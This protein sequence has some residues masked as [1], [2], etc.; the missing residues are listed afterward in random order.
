MLR[1]LRFFVLLSFLYAALAQA[2]RPA[3]SP[4]EITK[5]VVSAID[6]RYLYA[7]SN[8]AWKNARS[9]ILDANNRDQKSTYEFIAAELA[10]LRDSELHLVTPSEAAAIDREGK[11]TAVG[12]GLI[13]FGID[14]VPETGEARVVTPW[15]GSPA[16]NKGVRPRD[17]I[18][19]V[20]GKPTASL[21]HEQVADALRQDAA[22]LVLRRGTKTLH[23]R[24]QRSEDP[25]SAVVGEVKPASGGKIAYIRIAQFTP[26]SGDLVRAKVKEFES[27]RLQGYILDLRNNPGGFLSATEA[28]ASVFSSG[29]LGAKVH[30]NGDAEPITSNSEPLTKAPVVLLVNEGTASAAEF[31]TGALQELRRAKVVGVP[32]YGR[33]QAQVYVPLADGY[34]LVIPSVQIRT[35]SGKVFKGAGLQPDFLVK[36]GPV[37]ESQLGTARDRQFQAAIAV[38]LK[39][40]A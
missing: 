19:S 22:D 2:S 15:V 30:R 20:N 33:G 26:N 8:P 38:L 39:I 35:P 27:D 17:V 5:L 11:G 32:T 9:R 25:L 37:A 13:D 28:I 23:V 1:I 16:A 18:V 3:S 10:R 29:T 40:K 24:L 34:G 4:T 6:E 12:T 14:V 31:L 7:D 21:D 36:S